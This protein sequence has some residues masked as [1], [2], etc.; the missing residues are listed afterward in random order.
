[1]NTGCTG[2]E[3]FPGNTLLRWVTLEV[4]PK[5]LPPPEKPTALANTEG[6][7]WAAPT[8]AR[9][10]SAVTRHRFHRF[11]DLSPKQG[12]DQRPGERVVILVH[13]RWPPVSCTNTAESGQV[14]A[15]QRRAGVPP[16][17]HQ[18]SRDGCATL[19]T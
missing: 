14:R 3:L 7:T 13:R 12:R 4:G 2:R 8:S 1:V 15:L 16:A 10:W 17:A 18:G 6:M 11:G 19:H 9:S 5:V